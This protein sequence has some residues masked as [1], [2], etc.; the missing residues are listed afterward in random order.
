MQRDV[1]RI[2]HQTYID[3]YYMHATWLSSAVSISSERER[4]TRTIVIPLLS[5]R[6]KSD[7]FIRLHLFNFCSLNA[8]T[9]IKMEKDLQFVYC[10]L[11]IPWHFVFFGLRFV[12]YLKLTWI[13][14]LE[15]LMYCIRECISH[16]IR[17]RLQEKI[18]SHFQID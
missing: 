9:Q 15:F 13:S 5:F 11:C 6:V 16:G 3:S 7:S 12:R 2:L 18:V 8:Q 10:F 17:F 4:E 14:C 1:K